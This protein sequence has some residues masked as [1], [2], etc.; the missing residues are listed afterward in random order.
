MQLSPPLGK[1]ILGDPSHTCDDDVSDNDLLLYESLLPENDRRR[2]QKI[3]KGKR[4]KRSDRAV[5]SP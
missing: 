2:R 1:S 4:Q 3:R 5:D